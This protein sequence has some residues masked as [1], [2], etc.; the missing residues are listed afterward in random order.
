L[1]FRDASRHDRN[2]SASRE[3]TLKEAKLT[4]YLNFQQNICMSIKT[5]T[6]S[7]TFTESSHT[8]ANYEAKTKH[9]NIANI[10]NIMF[11]DII[12]HLAFI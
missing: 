9:E 12:H 5:G 8:S 3:F 10:T 7:K 2:T 11:L 4:K 1:T 6:L